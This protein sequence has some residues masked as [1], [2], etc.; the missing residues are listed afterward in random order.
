MASEALANGQPVL[1]ISH[2]VQLAQALSNRVGIQSIYEVRSVREQGKESRHESEIIAQLQGIGLCIDS[3][4]PYSQARFQASY[5]KNALIIIDEVEQV[6]WHALDSSTCQSDRVSILQELKELLTLALHPDSLGR[7]ILS[8]ADLIDV[9]IDFVM[10]TAGQP[11]LTPWICLNEWK[12]EQGWNIHNYT[13]Q[14]E[15]WLV[16]LEQHI[17]DGGRSSC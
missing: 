6:L 11:K 15:E 13:G 12:P 3:L 9:S 4:H 1:L 7:V 14:K 5:W 8:D 17:K 10:Q 16:G 2:R